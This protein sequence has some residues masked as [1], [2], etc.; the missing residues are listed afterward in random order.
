MRT[1]R[2]QN[3]LPGRYDTFSKTTPKDQ[4]KIK[5]ITFNKNEKGMNK[6]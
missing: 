6:Y 1:E 5:M 4:M 2:K 3:I